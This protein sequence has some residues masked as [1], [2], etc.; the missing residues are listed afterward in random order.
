[1]IGTDDDAIRLRPPGARAVQI[2]TGDLCNLDAAM[3]GRAFDQ[4]EPRAWSCCC[5]RRTSAILVCPTAFDLGEQL[6][7]VLPRSR[8]GKINRSNTRPLFK[9]RPMWW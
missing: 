5:D 3:V 8:K 1:L 4:L 9:I 6:R 7:L 2:Q